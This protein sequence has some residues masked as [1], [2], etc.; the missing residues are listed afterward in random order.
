MVKMFLFFW[1]YRFIIRIWFLFIC[2]VSL[3]ICVSV[4][5]GFRV[6]MIFFMC[7]RSWNVL[8]VLLFMIGMYLIWLMFFN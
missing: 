1:L 2:G 3:I 6:G 8:S 5:V 4:W 7:V